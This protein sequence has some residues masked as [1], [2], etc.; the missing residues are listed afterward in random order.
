MNTV[1][2]EE[3]DAGRTANELCEVDIYVVKPIH[4]RKDTS[5]Q[6]LSG[7]LSVPLPE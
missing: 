2:K 6:I 3:W 7:P 5:Y 1:N 4:D